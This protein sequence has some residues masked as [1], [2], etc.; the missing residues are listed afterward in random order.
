MPFTAFARLRRAIVGSAASY[1]FPH[2]QHGGAG[3]SPAVVLRRF[4]EV[5]AGCGLASGRRSGG[6]LPGSR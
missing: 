4:G 2:R 1:T 3:G 5:Q 6:R